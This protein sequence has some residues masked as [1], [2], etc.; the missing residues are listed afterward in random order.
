MVHKKALILIAHGSRVAKT[1]QEMDAYVETISRESPNLLVYGC[2]MEIQ[3]PDLSETMTQVIESGVK[4]IQVLPLFIFEGRHM[5][6]DIPAQVEACQREFPNLSIELLPYIGG[7][8]FFADA[9]LK[10]IQA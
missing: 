9:L 8:S 4:F 3:K 6:E 2:Y 1:Q 10:S 5:R 7:T